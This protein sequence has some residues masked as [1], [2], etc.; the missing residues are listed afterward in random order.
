MHLRIDILYSKISNDVYWKYLKKR[1]RLKKISE[2]K[3]IIRYIIHKNHRCAA[4]FSDLREKLK[5]FFISTI[6]LINILLQF[7]EQIYIYF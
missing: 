6:P 5:L 4:S 2:K 3:I 7:T 1:K